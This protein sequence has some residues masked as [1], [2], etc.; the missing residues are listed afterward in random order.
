MIR[1]RRTP[2]SNL[3]PTW[4]LNVSDIDEP[5]LFRETKVARF[6]FDIGCAED[7]ASYIFSIFTSPTT[8]PPMP[9]SIVW[10]ANR[11]HPVGFNAILSFTADGD[12]VI[13]D[14]DGS[15]AWTTNTAGKSVVGMNLTHTG[16]LVLYDD[17]NMVV[18][19]SFD[20]PTD[21]L[22]PG[23]RLFQGQKMKSSVSLTNSSEGMYYLQV[24]DVGLF[25]YV[26]SNPPQ[27]YYGKFI[28]L[29]SNDTNK[30]R[31]IRFL[32][33]SLSFFIG[34]SERSDPD[35]ASY[36]PEASSA[37]YMQL[38]P[39]GHLQVFEWQFDSRNWIVVYDLTAEGIVDECS[40]P[41]FCGR[42]AICSANQQCSCPE[43][44]HFRPVKDR[45]QNLGC[46]ENTAL[47]CNSTQDQDFIKLENVTYFT[48]T[49]DK[50]GVDM[51]TCKQACLNNCSCK[52][53]FFSIIQM[54]QL[55]IVFLPTEIFTMRNDDS[56]Y[57]APLAFIKVQND[58]SSPL[59]HQIPTPKGSLNH[60]SHRARV[61][62]STIGSIVL[63][64]V[65]VIG[66][67]L[68][69]VQKRKKDVEME[70][71]YLDQV[72]GMPTR[73]S[74]DELR[75]A[76][77]S[78]SKKLGEGGFGSVFVGSL[79]DG[80]K[81]AVKCLEGLSH[82]KQSFLA[83]VQTIGSIHH[84][85]LVRLRG[86]CTWKS[87]QFL[88][89]DFMS[90]G[91]L[92]RWIYH[93]NREHILEWKCRKKIILDIAKGLAYLHE[94]CMQKIIHLDIKPQNILLDEKFNAK[95]SDFGLSKLIDRNQSQVMTT[96][97]GTP[98]YLAPEWLS[99]V[100]TEKVDVYSFGIVLLE[101]LCGRPN[102]ERSQPEENRHLLSVFQKCWEQGTL[103]DIVDNNSEDMQMNSIEVVEMMKMAS[104]C[105][106]ADYTQRPSMSTVVKVLEGGTNVEPNMDYNFTDP[107]LLKNNSMEK[108]FTVLLPSILSGPSRRIDPERW[109]DDQ[110]NTFIKL[111]PQLVV[112]HLV[113][114]AN[115]STTWALDYDDTPGIIPILY[116]KTNIAQFAFGFT[117]ED[118]CVSYLLSI[119]IVGPSADIYGRYGVVWSANRNH[120]VK[121]NAIVNFTAAGDMVLKDKDGNTVW[122]TNTAGKSVVGMNLTDNGNLV[123]FD[124]HNLVV[125]QSFDYPTDTLLPGQILSQ[126]QKL[127]ASVSSENS[128]EGLYYV[129]VTEDGLVCYVESNPPQE[130]FSFY[131]YNHNAIKGRKY[132]KFLIGSL[133]L[134]IDS[135]EPSDQLDT[136]II[137]IS[138]SSAQYIQLTQDGEFLAS[139]WES[140][141]QEWATP[142]DILGTRVDKCSYPFVCGR[143]A[144]CSADDQQCSCPQIEHFKPVKDHQ[145]KQGC[146]EITPI[147]CSYTKDQDFIPLEHT[148]Y[149]VST[150]DM[151]GVNV[152]TCKQA[153]LKNCSCKAAFFWYDLNASDGKCLL[154]S[155][156]FTMQM[157]EDAF[158]EKYIA[159]LKVQNITSHSLNALPPLLHQAPTVVVPRNRVSHQAARVVGSTIGSFVLLLVALMGFIKYV[160][161]KRKREAT[162]E[163]E[164][165]DQV[166][167]MPNRFSYEELTMA[168]DNFSRKLGEGGFGLVFEGRLNDGS[169]IAV[170][171]LEGLSHIKKSF[172][173]EVQSIGSI[174][175]VNLVRL[176]GFC[177][178]K[179]RKFLVYDFMSNGSLDRWIY[180][181]NREHMLEWECRKKI[182]LDIAKGLAYLHEECR[183]KII[184]LDIKPQN[185]LLDD[186]FNAKVSD[187][188]LSKLIDRN[189]SHVMTT[190]RGTP[191]YL[192]PEWLSSVITE[193]V[194]VYSF[195]IVLLE[196]LC[197][198][199][200]FDRS[201]PEEKWHLLSV[202]QICWEQG[203]LL[204][205]VDMS[206]E[207]MIMY[208]TE[209]V[210]IMKMASWCLQTDYTRRPSM[211]SVVM[212]LEGG[213]NVESNLNY[214]FMDPRLPKN[215][216]QGKDLTPLLAS[217]LSGPR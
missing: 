53:A 147:N 107:R 14:E 4:T 134:F 198:R 189:Q 120:P 52:A 139:A 184:H 211:S 105:L 167:G 67:I 202:F 72:P 76:T 162:M 82:I 97:R 57:F 156:L 124:D 116:R 99:S 157:S 16:N 208:G 180:H 118:G 126:G 54:V 23:Q 6:A 50:E 94:E 12:L 177:T 113:Q 168:T 93:G 170:K 34:S 129:Q 90:N 166:P 163:D 154:I 185:I 40:Y 171:C 159:Y 30:K 143:N 115:H 146:Y 137:T 210:E 101:I 51:E 92:D 100:I 3:S 24:T 165:L 9:A 22:L 27:A 66:F 28:D 33:G 55:E 63:V 43:I 182:I 77:E 44:E 89:Y 112:G 174:H 150:P 71:E 121:E 169:K 212:V 96:M 78:F 145:P 59:P 110:T 65:M 41:L 84:V 46:T 104:W 148:T 132:I 109:H 87:Q 158:Y 127:K 197:G 136:L 191:G 201:Q 36:I 15:I 215:N 10:S 49:A 60:V 131:R 39:N 213:M 75:T 175:H 152:T 19:Q 26:E 25:A 86:F 119:I 186:E 190:M 199:K 188:G 155:E 209:I 5:V 125:W 187:F 18:W 8:E 29:H 176:R 133:S 85:N 106:Q 173:A 61:V 98:G 79:K 37:Q 13:K 205:I 204:D 142:V 103:L 130:Y 7:C 179:S 68:Y 42:N 80:S 164:Y 149:F 138:S 128:S 203:T 81:I 183:Q 56:G 64:L 108:E 31:H 95:V 83:E 195:G 74:Y 88:V 193:K 178:W 160:V 20:H 216:S 69:V 58:I 73:F 140:K 214:N 1:Y 217:V 194:D 38:M 161:Y 192:A 111:C 123:L 153:C 32:N 62:V 144:I 70:K 11:N 141:S 2:T 117:C 45:Q 196:I 200:N 135:S 172:L 102:F 91:S 122:T 114:Q 48:S 47:T 206:S 207:D 151:E 35:D 21:C 17:Q 181:G